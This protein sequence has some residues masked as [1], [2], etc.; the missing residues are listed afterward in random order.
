MG[1]VLDSVWCCG[2]LKAMEWMESAAEGVTI[3]RLKG[4]ID[5]QASPALRALLQAQSKKHVP[6]LL[7]DFSEVVYIDSSGLATLVEYYQQSRSHGGRI[8][9]AA[10][11]PRVRSI[12][13]L[14]RLN[15][16]FPIFDTV[17][18]AQT[19]LRTGTAGSGPG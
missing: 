11:S 1:P 7:L 12:F 16:I 2:T 6:V 17:A 14:V 15:E 19:E 4:E 13:D 8:A 5:L 10:L 3:F 9:L 18:V